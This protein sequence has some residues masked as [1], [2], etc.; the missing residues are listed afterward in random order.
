MQ[1]D[2]ARRYREGSLPLPFNFGYGIL[3]G[4]HQSN[5]MIALKKF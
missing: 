4:P 5:L 1:K 2:L 3:S